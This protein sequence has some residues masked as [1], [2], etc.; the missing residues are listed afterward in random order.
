MQDPSLCGSTVSPIINTGES[1][2]STEERSTGESDR[3]TVEGNTRNSDRSTAKR[4]TGE[5]DRS[6]AERYN[7]GGSDKIS[8]KNKEERE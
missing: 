1:D 2:R 8:K 7:T 5:S 3:S 4:N 6:P